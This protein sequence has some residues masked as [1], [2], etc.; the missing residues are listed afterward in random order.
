MGSLGDLKKQDFRVWV[1]FILAVRLLDMFRR[2]RWDEKE[3]NH[4]SKQTGQQF[5]PS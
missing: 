5:S 3:H 4:T 1:F 2:G